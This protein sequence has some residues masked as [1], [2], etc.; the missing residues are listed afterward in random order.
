MFIELIEIY[1]V[2]NTYFLK[3][4]IRI[5][6]LKFLPRICFR[7]ISFDDK[8]SYFIDFGT[9]IRSNIQQTNKRKKD[10]NVY[11]YICIKIYIT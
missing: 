3:K 1:N 9:N 2:H 7:L 6:V 8:I 11:I 10:T 4:I 5:F